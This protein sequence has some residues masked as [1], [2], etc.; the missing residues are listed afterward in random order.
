MKYYHELT[1]TEKVNLHSNLI[2]KRLIIQ[3][4]ENLLFFN[5]EFKYQNSK[6]PGLNNY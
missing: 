3:I 5:Y 6:L 2:F 1:I 4:R